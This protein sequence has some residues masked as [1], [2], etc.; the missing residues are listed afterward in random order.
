MKRPK[1]GEMIDGKRYYKCGFR[2]YLLPPNACVFC[3]HCTDVFYDFGGIYLLICEEFDN[4]YELCQCYGCDRY[5]E[6][7]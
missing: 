3:D 5:K 2:E 7:I 6:D 1:I 4:P